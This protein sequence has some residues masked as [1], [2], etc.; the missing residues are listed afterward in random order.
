V[1]IARVLA[2]HGVRGE[3]KCAVITDIPQRFATTRT[4][5]LGPARQQFRVQRARVQGRTVLLQLEG[6]TTRDAAERWRNAL[7]EVPRAERVRLPK[8]TYYWQDILGLQVVTDQ[9]EALG[10]IREILRTGANDVY[11]VDTVRGELLLPAIKDV[12]LHIDLERR[13]MRVH[14]L[15]G[16]R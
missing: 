14:L 13:E 4:V 3:L 10:T 1:V 16:M 12:V 2:P 6:I 11:V 9:G 7:V 15:E 8:D 5:H